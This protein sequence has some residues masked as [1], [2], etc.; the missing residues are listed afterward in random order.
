MANL[1]CLL[2]LL[3]DGK[4]AEHGPTLLN[5]VGLAPALFDTK[6]KQGHASVVD[7]ISRTGFVRKSEGNQTCMRVFVIGMEC[8]G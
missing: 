5:D 3:A 7:A 1:L 2:T 8:F 4:K 6:G